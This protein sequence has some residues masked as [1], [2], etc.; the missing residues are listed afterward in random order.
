MKLDNKEKLL[1]SDKKL[2]GKLQDTCVMQN[3]IDY[4]LDG[5]GDGL[6]G[7]VLDDLKKS[8]LAQRR[9]N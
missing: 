1:D 6:P 2:A 3:S 4:A 5:I 8:V 7:K 9:P